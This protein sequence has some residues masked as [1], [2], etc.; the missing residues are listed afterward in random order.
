MVL[1][2]EE[3][4]LHA[5]FLRE[6]NSVDDYF[7]IYKTSSQAIRFTRYQFANGNI[8]LT[9]R[10]N[11]GRRYEVEYASELNPTAWTGISGQ[12]LA[13]T[14]LTTWTHSPLDTRGFYRIRQ[15]D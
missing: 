5:R 8:A 4:A 10:S 9:W 15:L 14:P 13:T 2:I 7:S 3:G 12:I 1:D 6:I 11:P